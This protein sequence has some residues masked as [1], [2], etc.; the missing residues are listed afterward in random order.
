MN[1]SNKK[2]DN[3][4]NHLNNKQLIETINYR[5]NNG[6]NDDDYIAELQLRRKQQNKK[7]AYVDGELFKLI[8]GE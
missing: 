8:K 2:G 4:F 3:M 6:L 1:K 5:Y 7:I